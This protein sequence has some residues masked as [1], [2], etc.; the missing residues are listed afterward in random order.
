[1]LVL[2]SVFEH[3]ARSFHVNSANA[4]EGIRGYVVYAIGMAQYVFPHELWPSRC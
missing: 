1:M 3:G 2:L 4:G